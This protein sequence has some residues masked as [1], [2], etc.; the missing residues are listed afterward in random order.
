[1]PLQYRIDAFREI[2]R[3]CSRLSITLNPASKSRP[4]GIEEDPTQP[5]PTPPV[6][7]L[8]QNLLLNCNPSQL[9]IVQS[10]VQNFFTKLLT[11]LNIVAWKNRKSIGLD[12]IPSIVL[13]KSKTGSS[14]LQLRKVSLIFP[15][16]CL[17]H[18]EVSRC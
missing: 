2:R 3:T 15:C 10:A 13:N 8:K 12:K 7:V 18:I 9:F 16:I 5:L 17:R 6:F 11:N 4:S 1:M 14:A